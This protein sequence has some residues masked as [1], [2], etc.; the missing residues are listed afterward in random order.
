MLKCCYKHTVGPFRIFYNIFLVLLLVS[1]TSDKSGESTSLLIHHGAD[2]RVPTDG[3]H[4]TALHVAV[5]RN[6]EAAAKV[7]I[8]SGCQVNTKV[9]LI[10]IT[11]PLLTSSFSKWER[12]SQLWRNLNSYKENPEKNLRPQRDSNPWP[13]RYRCDA[14]PEADE[15]TADKQKKW[16]KV[17]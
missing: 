2:L 13:P 14:S 9:R 17:T 7:L 8:Q 3:H 6:N 1:F 12:S 4:L 5:L 15:C 16:K 11:P 10:W